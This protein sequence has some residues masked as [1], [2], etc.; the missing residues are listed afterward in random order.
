MST[1][2]KLENFIISIDSC[3]KQIELLNKTKYKEE[4]E[5]YFDFRMIYVLIQVIAVA[6]KKQNKEIFKKYTEELKKYNYKKNKYVKK[7]LQK[8]FKPIKYFGTY[9]ILFILSF[10]NL[11][12]NS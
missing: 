2:Y 11:L 8:E 3:K 4:L 1:D 10:C 9:T 12:I 5:E 7:I 6:A